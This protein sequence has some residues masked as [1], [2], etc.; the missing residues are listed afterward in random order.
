MKLQILAR[1]AKTKSESK[2]LRREGKIPAVIYHGGKEAS[3]I[4]I[5]RNEL[6]TIMRYMQPGR[7]STQVFTLSDANG[8]E[9]K[10]ILK[11]V[12]YNIVNYNVIHLDFEELHDHIYVNVKVPIECT[13]T[14]DCIGVKQGGAIR[15]VIRNVRVRCLPKDIPPAFSVNVA[16]MAMRDQFRLKQ[17]DMPNTIKPQAN[18]EEVAIVIVKR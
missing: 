3:N 15:Q 5:H 7:L 6:D 17:I 4:T 12:Q 14:V 9:R 8:K 13:G 18:M 1:D 11:E 2:Q 16:S 10:A